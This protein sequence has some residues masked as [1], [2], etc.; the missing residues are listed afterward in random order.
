[1]KTYL[2]LI[3]SIITE[4]FATTMLKISEGFTVPFPSFAAIIGYGFSFYF[5]GLT[6]KTMPLS[7]AYAIWA[8]AGTALTVLISVIFWGEVLSILKVIG[9][10]LIISGVVVLNTAKSNETATTL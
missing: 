10:L 7:L 2:F 3:I 5:L 4:V 9:I 6:L 1:M 8:G